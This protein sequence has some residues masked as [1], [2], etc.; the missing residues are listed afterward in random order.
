MHFRLATA[1]KNPL[2]PFEYKGI[3]VTTAE[4]G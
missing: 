1:L 4:S 3:I 2:G